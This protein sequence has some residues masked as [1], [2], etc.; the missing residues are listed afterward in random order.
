[1][2]TKT[3]TRDGGGG[4]GVEGVLAEGE[5]YNIL[6]RISTKVFFHFW[7]IVWTGGKHRGKSERREAGGWAWWLMAGCVREGGFWNFGTRRRNLKSL[8]KSLRK[9]ILRFGIPVKLCKAP[10]F[11]LW[12]NPWTALAAAMGG[13]KRR[14]IIATLWVLASFYDEFEFRIL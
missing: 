3:K 1:M 8:A 2:K 10:R 9:R 4:A 14:N 6:I 5:T 7:L 11:R 12:L 13:G